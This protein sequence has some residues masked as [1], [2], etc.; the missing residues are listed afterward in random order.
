VAPESAAVFVHGLFSA[1]KT[2]DPLIGLLAK[3]TQ[4]SSSYD[5]MRFEY[6][7]PRWNWRL[8][9]RIPDFNTIADSLAT[10]YEVECSSYDRLVLI[11][12]SQGG[13][14]IQRFL[15]RMLGQS[16]GLELQRIRRI[17]LL[18]CPNNGSEFLL[19][20]RKLV[21]FWRNR[22]ERELRPITDSVVEAQ[23]RVLNN[24]VHADG[25][26]SD[27]C[28]I[29]FAVYAGESDNIVTPASAG[30]VF[31]RVG[32]LPGDHSSILRADSTEHRTF[33][34][35]KA[36]L[37]LALSES[38]LVGSAVDHRVLQGPVMLV[39]TTEGSG[40]KSQKIEIFDA[41]A[42][43]LWIQAHRKART[44]A[45]ANDADY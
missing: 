21:A 6:Q 33:T 1:G 15:S 31:P 23:R 17:V 40:S 43:N 12:H 36:N 30:S 7:S 11:S 34:T 14:I 25:A 8:T 41:N 37:Q 10:F 16:R 18:A 45:D 44:E 26:S 35:V 13:L 24:I 2:W 4:V 20:T 29:P 42:A 5:L 22:Q 32:A 19:V 9:R 28:P 39:T 38:S 3:D 27:R